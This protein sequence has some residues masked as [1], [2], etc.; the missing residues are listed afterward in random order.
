MGLRRANR[1]LALYSYGLR[2][3]R[4]VANPDRVKAS[5]RGRQAEQAPLVIAGTERNDI[6]LAGFAMR[7]PTSEGMIMAKKK[8]ASALKRLAGKRVVLAEIRVWCQG[9][10]EVDGRSAT[11]DGAG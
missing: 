4:I 3:S 2:S 8:G 7:L 5:D 9:T 10:A 1:S 11:G 6:M